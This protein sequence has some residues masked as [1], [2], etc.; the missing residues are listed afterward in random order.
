M[1]PTLQADPFR[2]LAFR[3]FLLWLL[4]SIPSLVLGWCSQAWLEKMEH[5]NP[6]QSWLSL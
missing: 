3:S 1:G 2:E 4:L 6:S 5:L